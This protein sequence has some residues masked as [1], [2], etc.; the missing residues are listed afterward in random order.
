MSEIETIA[1][2]ASH[3]ALQILKG[4]KDEGFK[5]L[6]ISLKKRLKV[7]QRFRHFIDDI[8]VVEDF[9]ELVNKD[10]QED[11]LRRKTILIPHGSFVEYLGIENIEKLEVPVFGNKK[12]MIWEYDA[13]RKL[14]LLEKS[15]IKT[16]KLFKK[17]QEI[18]RPV[19]VKFPGAKGGRGYFIARN[20]EEFRKKI[21]E[22][23]LDPAQLIIQEYVFGTPMYFHYFYSPLL[24]RLELLG[25]DIRYESEV[26]GIK[27][28]PYPVENYTFTVVGNIPLVLRESLLEQ[29]FDYGE[30]FVE[31]TKKFLPPGAIGPFCLEA[32]C[33]SDLEIVV[34]EFSG[35]IV[36]GTNLYIHGSPYSW[37]YFDEPMSSGRRIAREIRMAL[38]MDA[39]DK[40]VVR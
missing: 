12:L 20:A 13:W 31:T 7:Y 15:G 37:L 21:K 40:I 27:R 30:K 4:A 16:P 18:D 34:F 35:R 2:L 25:A 17:V 32:I 23:N 28:Y 29:V 9:K 19:I 33:R 14:E 38:E 5:T 6:A 8:I 3:S 1:T 22:R 36:A 39:L 10:I 26:D 24:N 11:L